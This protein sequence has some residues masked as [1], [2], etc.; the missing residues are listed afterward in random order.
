MSNDPENEAA[1]PPSQGENLIQQEEEEEEEDSSHITVTRETDVLCGRGG[2]A[3]RHPG[4]QTYRRL[5]TLNKGLYTTCLKAE[6]L[7]IS[8]SIV[9]AVREQKGRFLE[10]NTDGSESWYDI[11][12]KKAVEKTSQALREGQPQLRKKIVELGGGATGAKALLESQLAAEQQQQHQQ[13]Q[14]HHQQ[15]QQQQRQV[16]HAKAYRAAAAAGLDDS[17]ATLKTDNLNFQGSFGD[18]AF[19]AAAVQQQQQAAMQQQHAQH[20]HD[21]MMPPPQ[22][23]RDVS[24]ELLRMTL[25]DDQQQQDSNYRH[26]RPSMKQLGQEMG[27]SVQASQMSLLSDF[28]GSFGMN[29]SVMSLEQMQAQHQQQQLQAFMREVNMAPPELGSPQISSITMPP[30][31]TPQ[32]SA[33]SATSVP[34]P[35]PQQQSGNNAPPVQADRRT[36]FARMKYNR[37][38]SGRMNSSG[39]MMGSMR[40]VGEGDGMPDVYPVE[41]KRSLLSNISSIDGGSVSGNYTNREIHASESKRSLMSILSDHDDAQSIISDLSKKIGNVSTRSIAMS[42]MSNMDGDELEEAAHEIEQ[43]TPPSSSHPRSSPPSSSSMHVPPSLSMDFE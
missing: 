21:S 15:Q 17:C 28:S 14:H 5:V 39:R 20:H 37:V 31:L 23:A 13:Q 2:K 30:A 19:A 36:M 1:A 43:Q 27:M 42:E 32:Q 35:P 40:S 38:A 29:E 25:N 7:K 24:T 9:A 3:L 10:K 33:A 41:S 22:T 6:K 11:E 26:L 34:Q 18:M 12:D 16:E 4:N 8:K